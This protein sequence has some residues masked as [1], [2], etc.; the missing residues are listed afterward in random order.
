MLEGFLLIVT[1]GSMTVF[2]ILLGGWSSN[3]KYALLG[4]IRS[5]AQNVAYEIPLLLSAL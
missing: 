4:A 5:V 2:A 3:N 1:F